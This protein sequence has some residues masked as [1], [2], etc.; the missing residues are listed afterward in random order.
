MHTITARG[1]WYC[2]TSNCNN[3]IPHGRPYTKAVKML[4]REKDTLNPR[5]L[6]NPQSF[7]GQYCDNVDGRQP[8]ERES[9]KK[10]PCLK[11]ISGKPKENLSIDALNS[12]PL[13]AALGNY[14]ASQAYSQLSSLVTEKL[15][16]RNRSFFVAPPPFFCNLPLES[17]AHTAKRRNN[18]ALIAA[19]PTYHKSTTDT[20]AIGP[21]QSSKLN[22]VV[23]SCRPGHQ[24]AA[25]QASNQQVLQ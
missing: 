6:A 5:E 22:A 4:Q 19:V 7:R 23:Q 14:Q 8:E 3:C 17:S 13:A 21:V 12:S 1:Y 10:Y 20:P 2:R 9:I 11:N 25:T 15:F 18:Q 16:F 24:H